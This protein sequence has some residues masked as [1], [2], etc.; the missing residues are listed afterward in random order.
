MYTH[1]HTHIL[2]G[3]TKTGT[4]AKHA[5]TN[6]HVC[7]NNSKSSQQILVKI[8]FLNI[9]YSRYPQLKFYQNLKKIK[10]LC[11]KVFFAIIVRN[12][13]IS[14]IWHNVIQNAYCVIFYY[15]VHDFVPTLSGSKIH[16]VSTHTGN[17]RYATWLLHT[18]RHGICS[19]SLYTY[20]GAQRVI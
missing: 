12:L 18:K 9:H 7:I 11:V 4:H 13:C 2:V 6:T 3:A 10:N 1:T 8:F 19:A 20:V 15:P 5:L 14:M 17:H 16:V